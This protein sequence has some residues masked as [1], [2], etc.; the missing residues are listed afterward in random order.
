MSQTGAVFEGR[1]YPSPDAAVDA[2]YS[3][4]APALSSGTT[5]YLTEFVKQSGDWH[6]K[7]WSIDSTG[8]HTLRYDVLAQVPTFQA[9]DPA[10]SFADGVTIGWGIGAAMVCA[11]AIKFM[12][13]IKS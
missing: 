5:S 1:C 8:T 3:G 9:C 7:S 12:E 13:K 10:E 4:A 2:Y 11:A 6:A